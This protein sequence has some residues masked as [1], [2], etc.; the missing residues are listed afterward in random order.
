MNTR[1]SRLTVPALL[2]LPLLGAYGG[3]AAI[4]VQDLPDYV[5]AGQPVTLSFIVRQ[6]GVSKLS[7]LKPRVEARATGGG[8]TAEAAAAPGREAGQY[9]ATLT[10]PRAGAWR[11]TIHSGFG[12]SQVTLLPLQAIAAGA[13]PPAPL[14][15]SERGQRLFVAKGC[16][17]C[18]VHADVEGS[19]LVA[20]GPDLTGRRLPADYLRQ[21]LANPAIA[22]RSGAP[23]MPNLDLK[24]QEIAALSAFITAERRTVQ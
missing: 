19:G 11:I 4:T 14:A 6:H 20:V 23:Q 22:A 18:H 17:T 13:A 5:V 16:L 12:N 8:T 10:L 9:V 21:F 1:P 7:G 3:W 15:D 24:P 2:L